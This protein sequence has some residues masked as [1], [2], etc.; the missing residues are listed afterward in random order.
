MGVSLVTN[1]YFFERIRP[2]V[3]TSDILISYVYFIQI[4]EPKNLRGPYRMKK[5]HIS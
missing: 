3:L 5:R 2:I 1:E 4:S